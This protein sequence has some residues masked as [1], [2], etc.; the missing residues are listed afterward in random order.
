MA[1]LKSIIKIEGTLDDLTFYK[2]KEGYLVKTK[3]GVSA[4]RIKN[5]PSFARTRENGTEFGNAATSGK[6]L[7][8]A[9][10][11]LLTDAK[12]DRVTSRL[13]QVM[14]RV[15]NADTIS[16]RGQRNVAVGITTP[17]GKLSL[18]GFNFNIDAIL[19]A[20]LLTDY[21]LNATTGE[22]EI[23]DFIPDQNLSKPEG[24]THLS[25]T[26]GFLNLDFASGDHDLITSPV[27]NLPIDNTTSTVTLTPPS[28]PTGSGNSFYFLKIA[29][30]QE[31]NSIQY[32]LNNG[33]YNALQLLDII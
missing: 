30:Y 16:P 3:G 31:V 22:V 1:K 20:V 27:V 18:I 14:S 4:N 33:A 12:D 28:V 24:A 15:K 26:S 8:R 29:F 5:D 32:A 23:I 17:Q 11:D 10:L 2:G 19:S 13:T 21:T 25:L 6:E 7:R 9:I